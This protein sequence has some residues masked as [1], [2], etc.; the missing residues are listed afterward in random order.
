MHLID[1]IN[2]AGVPCVLTGP[3]APT[4]VVTDVRTNISHKQQSYI[5]FRLVERKS[6]ELG[7][8]PIESFESIYDVETVHAITADGLTDDVSGIAAKH[9]ERI[10]ARH[11]GAQRKLSEFERA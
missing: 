10:K 2:D 4:V 9:I 7:N 1:D 3:D 5:G 11:G 6:P 8:M